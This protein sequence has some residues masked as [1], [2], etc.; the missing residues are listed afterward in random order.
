MR[1][2]L[3]VI[4]AAMI[5]ACGSSFERKAMERSEALLDSIIGPKVKSYTIMD[6]EIT[7]SGDSI[8]ICHYTANFT[9]YYD[10]TVSKKM[11]YFIGWTVR[12]SKYEPRLVESLYPIG[13]ED[14]KALQDFVAEMYEKKGDDPRNSDKSEYEKLLRTFAA[15]CHFF[16]LK[17][18][19]E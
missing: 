19:K 2:F 10:D 7:F 5:T 16:E 18:I 17:E 13:G 1:I 3:F 15:A 12:T 14:S 4:F 6:K 8:C 11:E 9:N